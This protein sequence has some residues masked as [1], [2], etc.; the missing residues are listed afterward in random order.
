MAEKKSANKIMLAV[1]LGIVVVFI[2]LLM[3]K[4]GDK[5]YT[6]IRE[7]PQYGPES[8]PEDGDSQADTIRALQ[9]YAKEAVGK[10][11]ELNES[12]KKHVTTVLENKN[13]VAKLEKDNADL[14]AT[15]ETLREQAMALANQL[16]SIHDE[17]ANVKEQQRKL[18]PGPNDHGIPVGFGYDH[19]NK[20]R[21]SEEGSWHNPVDVI[22]ETDGKKPSGGFN[23]LLRPPGNTLK[24]RSEIEN[25]DFTKSQK[26]TTKQTKNTP[27]IDPVYTI[28]KDSILYDGV[29][30]TA[31]I[32]RIPVEG[33]TPD[34]Y[35]VKI[36]VGAE[37]LAANGHQLPDVK[38]M[39]FSG[40]GIGDWNLSCVRARL[41]SATYIFEDGRIVN[42]TSEGE[43]LGYIS[44]RHGWPC[45]SGEFK[46]NAMKFLS[47]RVG[48]AATGAAGAAYADAQFSKRESSQTG[49]VIRDLTGDIEKVVGGTVVRSATDEASAW[50]LAR[51]KQ[52][53]DAVIIPP[54]K[55]ISVHIEKMLAIDKSELARQV[56]YEHSKDSVFRTL[57]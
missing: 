20:K 46:S 39:I 45:A 10:A 4:G 2:V 18:T 13:D 57:D 32:G 7:L 56:R 51:Q 27:N 40:W 15:S 21:R 1:V 54:G 49:N 9:A 19:L 43:P 30:L 50:L 22:V 48:L 26:R 8:V 11:E 44:D 52:S 33:T 53:F 42:H 35:P 23:S 25:E 24:D 3:S 38:G 55:S 12:T 5:A 6:P 14:K 34:P 37:N 17:L 29:A 28:P 36:F 31:L 41:T 16:E 47:Q